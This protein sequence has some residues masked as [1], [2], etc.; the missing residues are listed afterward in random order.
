MEKK[1]RLLPMSVQSFEKLRENECLYVDKTEYVYRLVHDVAHFFLSRPRRFGKSLLLSTLRAYWEGKKDLF[2]G[3]AIETLE[4][5]NQNAWQPYPVFYFDFNGRNY[6]DHALETLL[7]SYL[8]QWEE[9][10]GISADG[11][12]LEERFENLLM[13]A[14]AKTGRRC[15]VLVD[16]YDKPLLDV[17][18]HPE[19]L[20]HNKTVLKGLFSNLKN[21]DSYI[22]FVF[23]T[24]VS[25]FHKVSIFG[26]LNQLR[27]IS[28]SKEF[29]ALCGI[30]EAELQ[31]NFAPEILRLAEEKRLSE[32]LC[33]E[34]LKKQYGGY[35]FHQD[36]INVY[37][38]FSLMNAFADREFGSYWFE[39]GTPTFLIKRL[40]EL[41]LDPHRF[42]DR[43]LYASADVLK[44][45]RPGNPNPLPLLYQTGYLT[46][47]G[48]DEEDQE[49]TL[50]FPNNEVRSGFL[51]NLIPS[52]CVNASVMRA[53]KSLEAD[54]KRR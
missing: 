41:N 37:N 8:S 22:Q 27:D 52:V 17:I 32:K 16:E 46:I 24:G 23:I 29:S 39:T 1:R 5:E 13:K 50:A 15:V 44:D 42:T 28:L 48:Y 30:T 9:T 36:G 7:S 51:K 31:E 43:T 14:Y 2:S 21:C 38:P 49:Y 40:K 12:T 20:E 4:S 19:K 54:S 25:A 45:Y 10:Y 53:E 34:E 35:K 26:E 3:L 6:I 18:D 11:K 47:A 33:L